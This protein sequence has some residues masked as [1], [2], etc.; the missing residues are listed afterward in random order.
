M[1]NNY[2]LSGL[3][4]VATLGGIGY[5]GFTATK[6]A[7]VQANDVEQKT[8]VQ[9][10]RTA[11]D[12]A[13]KG[14]YADAARMLEALQKRHPS[15]SSIALNLGIAYSALE[16]YKLAETQFQRVLAVN[17]KDW[18]AVAERAVVKAVSGDE[19][20]GFGLLES[21]PVGKGQLD[22]R[23]AA[24]PVWLNAKDKARLATLR[25]KHGVGSR[26]DSSQR[27]VQEMERRRLEF[28][29]ANKDRPK[30]EGTTP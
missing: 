16:Q 12:A 1:S 19:P 24:D 13:N 23:L 22:K 15:S 11:I 9:E 14:R 7:R 5:G 8:V 28:E 25:Q 4:L 26:G 3:W 2:V 20:A 27:R 17:P 21:I 10:M 6:A 29:R 30:Q 18:D